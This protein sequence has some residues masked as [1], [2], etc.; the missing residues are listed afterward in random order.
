M[1][2]VN[3]QA[4]GIIENLPVSN[5]QVVK[6]GQ[7]LAQL[8]SR[9]QQMALE[10]ARNSLLRAKVEMQDFLLGYTSNTDTS[11]IPPQ[12]MQTA[13]IRSGLEEAELAVREHKYM[14][15]KTR[16]TAPIAGR[17]VDLKAKPHNPTSSYEYLCCIV[18]EGSLQVAFNVLESELHM[19][20]EGAQVE[21]HPFS[22]KSAQVKG[23]IAEINRK[24]DKNGMVGIVA[25]LMQSD[26][27]IIPGMNVR[28]M[29]RKAEPKMLVIPVD[30]LTRRQNR[31]VV[32]VMRD[33]LAYW[34]Y[35]DAGPRNTR[36]VVI[37]E[38]LE[39]DDLV[40]ASGNATIGHEA[41]VKEE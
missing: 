26:N 35:V 4:Q 21:V 25:R 27:R 18:D 32:F 7:L 40:I 13:R 16:I 12:V 28:V 39:E 34:Q 14:L 8:D 15:S 30:G 6:Q 9:E 33:T 5:G 2:Q 22:N 36:E 17:V 41:W 38:G 24:V 31:D 20:V 1:A 3:F 11:K 19:A 23:V 37:H 10:R 29:V